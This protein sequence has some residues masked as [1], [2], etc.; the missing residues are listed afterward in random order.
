MAQ[1]FISGLYIKAFKNIGS[2][3]LQVE[4]KQGLNAVVGERKS[5]ITR[6]CKT[7]T[8]VPRCL[9]LQV[10]IWA[11][12]SPN[13]GREKGSRAPSNLYCMRAQGPMAAESLLCWRPSASPLQPQP[14]HSMWQASPTCRI[15]TAPR[16]VQDG[17]AAERSPSGLTRAELQG[18]NCKAATKLWVLNCAGL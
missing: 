4:L 16:R 9:Q 12:C 15:P 5:L 18:Y 8:G 7:N 11:S 17:S 6:G 3:G 13:R 14:A 10:L 1:F 2:E